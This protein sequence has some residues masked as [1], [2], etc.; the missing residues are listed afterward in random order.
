VQGDLIS[1]H[2]NPV[3]LKTIEQANVVRAKSIL[4]LG[5]LVGVNT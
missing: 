1:T 5:P 4:Q 3:G 2:T